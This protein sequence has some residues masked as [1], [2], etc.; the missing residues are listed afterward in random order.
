MKWVW[1]NVCEQFLSSCFSFILMI[2]ALFL[3]FAPG[4]LSVSESQ[5]QVEMLYIFWVYIFHFVLNYVI[6]LCFFFVFFNC[7]F[8]CK[9][10]WA[11]I[12]L[13]VREHCEPSSFI[14]HCLGSHTT[15]CFLGSLIINTV[16]TVVNDNVTV[17]KAAWSIIFPILEFS[18]VKLH[19]EQTDSAT[20]YFVCFQLQ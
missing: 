10:D 18:C 19:S 15:H 14:N 16:V 12:V 2:R 11:M 1:R 6:L 20:E 5:K 17:M 9:V 13:A 3:H 4:F 8:S 7:A